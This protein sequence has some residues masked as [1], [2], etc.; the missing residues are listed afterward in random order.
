MHY[1]MTVERYFH[2]TATGQRYKPRLFL[3]EPNTNE[4]V[5][6]N[7]NDDDRRIEKDTKKDENEG[8]LQTLDDDPDK[9]KVKSDIL[10]HFLGF[11]VFIYIYIYTL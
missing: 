1:N 8:G 10:S 9:D 4:Q 5:L 3:Q 11:K 2:D 7:Y 6:I